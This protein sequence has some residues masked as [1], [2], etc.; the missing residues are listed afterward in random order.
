MAAK[1]K[2]TRETK[3]RGQSKKTGVAKKSPGTK[4][5]TAAAQ[6]VSRTRD[7]A[8]VAGATTAA[9]TGTEGDLDRLREA[10]ESVFERLHDIDPGTLPADKKEEYWRDR[11]IART[12][13]EHAENAAFESLVDQQKQQLPA[14]TASNAK[15]A[16]DVQTTETVIGVLNV[17]SAAL[18]ILAS[19][20]S[21]LA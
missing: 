13:W 7:A 12:A 10:T 6:T 18:G 15:L 16:K 8:G 19:V 4:S 21:L 2:Q 9:S 14:V 11:H 5:F 17:V 3:G 1:T 20:I